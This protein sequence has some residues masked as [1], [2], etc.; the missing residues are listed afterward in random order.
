MDYKS[1]NTVMKKFLLL[2]LVLGLMACGGIFPNVTEK[3]KAASASPGGA[4]AA[5]VRSW[6]GATIEEVIASWREIPTEITQVDDLRTEYSFFADEQIENAE[7]LCERAYEGKG[8]AS[9]QI[10]GCIYGMYHYCTTVMVVQNGKVISVREGSWGCDKMT[11][12]P[13]RLKSKQP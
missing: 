6:I 11:T 4:Y 9:W 13:S 5:A 7:A 2:L 3:P 8:A 1:A 10:R 12:P